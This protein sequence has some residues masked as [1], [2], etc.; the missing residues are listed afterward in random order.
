DDDGHAPRPIDYIQRMLV[1]GTTTNNNGVYHYHAAP[2]TIEGSGLSE[3]ELREIL[4]EH[5]QD[6]QARFESYFEGMALQAARL[7]N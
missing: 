1:N 3:S 2:I 4:D 6:E 7:E 5:R